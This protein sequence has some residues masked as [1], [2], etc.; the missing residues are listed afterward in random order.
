MRNV[1]RSLQLIAPP[2][3]TFL[4]IFPTLRAL[5][6]VFLWIKFILDSLNLWVVSNT[7]AWI[8]SKPTSCHCLYQV[9]FTS[10]ACKITS[11]FLDRVQI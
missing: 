10:T 3:N 9:T 2:G 4:L 5:V 8:V 7:D 11:E 1:T 6:D